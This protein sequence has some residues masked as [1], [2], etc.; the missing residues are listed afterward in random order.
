VSTFDAAIGTILDHE[1]GLVDHPADPGGLT[2]RGITWETYCQWKGARATMD[3]LR[4]LSVEEATA[5]YRALYWLPV[6]DLIDSQDV[7]TKTFDMT[8]NMGHRQAHRLIQRATG[9]CGYR[10]APD[11]VFGP[12]TLAAVNS[13]EPSVLLLAMCHHQADFYRDLA[14]TRPSMAVFL[15]GWLERAAW[16]SNDE[17]T[18]RIA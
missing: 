5:I 12:A 3:E 2:N 10:C 7:A 17:R 14:A 18:E 16:M 15:H 13:C 8:V 4:A 9:D 6:Y 11:G 1:G